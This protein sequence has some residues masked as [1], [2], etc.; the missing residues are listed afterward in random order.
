MK[1]L[2]FISY[3]KIKN[4]ILNYFSFLFNSKK[5]HSKTYPTFVSLET[6]AVCNLHCPECAVGQKRVT[7]QPFMNIDLFKKVI[8]EIQDYTLQILLYFQGEPLLHPNI[9][10]M[11][12]Y[13]NNKN[14]Y[15]YL[16]TNAQTLDENI[17]IQIVK[18]QLRH[19]VISIDG[20]T[21]Q[22]YEQYRVGGSLEK[23]I[24]AIKYLKKE[25]ERQYSSFPKIEIQFVV[26]K[27][28]EN[29]IKEIKT[30]AKEWG[31]NCISIKSAQIYNY[32]QKSDIIPSIKKYSRYVQKNGLW[33][34]KKNIKNRC[35]KSW[36]GAVINSEGEVLPCCFDKQ[37]IFTF[38][39]VKH[40]TLK[41]IFHN[42]KAIDFRNQ[43]KKN[44]NSIDICTNCTE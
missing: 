7:R 43:I 36:A 1:K 33:Q 10:E 23:A 29:E 24:Q 5:L 17:S 31:A 30:L 11:I 39:N 26:F 41:D 28:N 8:D 12:K 6:S 37:S 27:H 22:S 42:Q 34:L 2:H 25:K 40:S 38:G 44:R 4:L 9:I 21:Q 20:I 32:K 19:I 18:S 15:T 3:L 35:F 13:A 14:L 16:S